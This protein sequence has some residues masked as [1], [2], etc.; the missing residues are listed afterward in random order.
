MKCNSKQLGVVGY[1]LSR[2]LGDEI[3]SIAAARLLPRVDQF[4]AR[5]EM[6]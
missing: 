6:D 5:E 1:P 2:N 4:I 3:Q